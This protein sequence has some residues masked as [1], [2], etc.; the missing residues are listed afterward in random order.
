M[1]SRIWG[2]VGDEGEHVSEI[3]LRL[4]TCA[5]RW[6]VLGEHFFPTPYVSR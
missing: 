5:A 1:V 3:T 6:R 4:V 2:G